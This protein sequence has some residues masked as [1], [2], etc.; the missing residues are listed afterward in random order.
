MNRDDRFPDRFA[1]YGISRRQYRLLLTADWR[2]FSFFRLLQV[3]PS[4]WQASL[5]EHVDPSVTR[6]YARF[7]DVWNTPYW[8]W[9]LSKAQF[10]FGAAQLPETFVLGATQ[11]GLAADHALL[12]KLGA[13]LQAYLEGP[14]RALGLPESLLLAVPLRGT[15]EQLLR[16]V[17]AQLDVVLGGR[18]L[19]S[20]APFEI[21]KE[22]VHHRT[23]KMALRVVQARALMPEAPLY[24]IGARANVAPSRDVQEGKRVS[25]SVDRRH[26][27]AHTARHIRRCL[28]LAE[29]AACGRF[30]SLA[31]HST[32][33]ERFDASL[34]ERLRA[35]AQVSEAAY[36]ELPPEAIPGAS[37]FAGPNRSIKV[38]PVPGH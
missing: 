17:G 37:Y 13:G 1:L 35:Y 12:T 28:V 38:S 2:Y 22:R 15:K 9:W 6:T 33:M 8:E 31:R 26:M 20:M 21:L 27:S 14:H 16:A 19:R 34:G 25:N 23:V 29:N 24:V 36:A 3:S 18:P 5:G 4:Y 10:E 32:T 7:G 30:P 11:E